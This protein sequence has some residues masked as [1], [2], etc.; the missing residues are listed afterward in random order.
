MPYADVEKVLIGYL[1]DALTVRCVTDLPSN[2]ADV[3]PIVQVT[4][5]AGKDTYPTLEAVMVDIDVYAEDRGAANVL[6]EEIRSELRFTAR[7]QVVDGA[8]IGLVETLL[9]PTWR[10]YENANIR[11]VGATYRVMIHSQL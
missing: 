4:R 10:P 7:G 5:I 8:V 2:L 11:R 3:T 6:S 9:G 1:A